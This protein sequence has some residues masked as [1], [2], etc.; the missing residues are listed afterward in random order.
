MAGRGWLVGSIWLSSAVGVWCASSSLGSVVFQTVLQL[1][2]L[3]LAAGRMA[4]AGAIR[5]W[6]TWCHYQ[7]GLL[8]TR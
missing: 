3:D 2:P 5:S 1:V 8:G 7:S 4:D 6:S